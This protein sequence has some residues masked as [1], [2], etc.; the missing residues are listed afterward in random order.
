MRYTEE[1]FEH[2]LNHDPDA[3]IEA[4]R[5]SFGKVILTALCATL[6]LLFV[7]IL[8]SFETEVVREYRIAPGDTLQG[9]TADMRYSGPVGTDTLSFTENPTGIDEKTTNVT[10]RVDTDITAFDHGDQPVVLRLLR[11]DGDTL[12]V[13]VTTVE[14]VSRKTG[15]PRS[16]TSS[17]VSVRCTGSKPCDQP[18]SKDG[19]FS[20]IFP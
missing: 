6:L 5:T 12:T 15:K 20:D 13:R 8:L 18:P 2:L 10:Y 3:D 9:N 19:T 1:D 11:R 16:D 17:V 14:S 7:D 4:R